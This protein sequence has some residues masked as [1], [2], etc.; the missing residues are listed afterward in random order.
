M[1]IFIFGPKISLKYAFS[2]KFR[3]RK[4]KKSLSERNIMH[5]TIIF[6]INGKVYFSWIKFIQNFEDKY[7]VV[8]LIEGSVGKSR[9]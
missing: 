1:K 8:L 2:V 6:G 7:N 3:G 9:P 5:L 4:K